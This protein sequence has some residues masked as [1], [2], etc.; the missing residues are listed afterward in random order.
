MTKKIARSSCIG[1]ALIAWSCAMHAQMAP[2]QLTKPSVDAVNNDQAAA[3]VVDENMGVLYCELVR[4]TPAS[5][6]R[7][8]CYDG[9][10]EVTPGRAESRLN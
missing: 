10:G 7:V 1:L 6:K 4:E 8:T 2:I 5:V 9:H 3:W